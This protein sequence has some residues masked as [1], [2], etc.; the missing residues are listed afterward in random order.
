MSIR[1]DLETAIRSWRS[2]REER[3]AQEKVA[4]K[5][6]EHE[7]EFK[8]FIMEELTVNEIEGMVVDGRVTD[9]MPKDVAVVKDR[10]LFNEFVIKNDALHLYSAAISQSAV[11]EMEQAGV[12]IPGIEHVTVF[13]LGDRKSK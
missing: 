8:K 1:S 12:V 6:K 7:S 10:A 5:I 11:K 13:E 2:T 4:A 3:L 9:L